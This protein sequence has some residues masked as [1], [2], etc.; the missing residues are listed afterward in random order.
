MKSKSACPT[1]PPLYTRDSG[2]NHKDR[3]NARDK[4]GTTSLKA[5]ALAALAVPHE[6]DTAGQEAGQAP[7]SCPMH[8]QALG[9][10]NSLNSSIADKP[11]PAQLAYRES[12]LVACPEHKRKLHC[13][14]CAHCH[15]KDRCREWLHLAHDVEQFE[16]GWRPESLFFFLEEEVKSGRMPTLEGFPPER[17]YLLH[18]EDLWGLF[19]NSWSR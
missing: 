4:P 14:F 5:L 11:T 18:P 1:V 8:S 6:R 19:D 13:W 9:T 16:K 2:T 3:D 17:A 10:K 12:I 15:K 7:K